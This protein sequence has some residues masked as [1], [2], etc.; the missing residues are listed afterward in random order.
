MK[1]F[2]WLRKF[3]RVSFSN[4]GTPVFGIEIETD[5]LG[6]KRIKNEVPPYLVS[7]LGNDG[8]TYELKSVIVIEDENKKPGD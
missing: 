7:G 1:F 4:D 8:P 6:P 3:F 2:K 5:K